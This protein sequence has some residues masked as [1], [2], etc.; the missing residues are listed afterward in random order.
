MLCSIENEFT[1]ST[2]KKMLISNIILR[3]KSE[4]MHILGAPYIVPIL[5]EY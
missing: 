5:L 1:A 3:D 4:K 2:C